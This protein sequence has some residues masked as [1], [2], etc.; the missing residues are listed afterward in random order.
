[1]PFSGSYTGNHAGRY[2][3]LVSESNAT[4]LAAVRV[5]SETTYI[6]DR[7][8]TGFSIVGDDDKGLSKEEALAI[9]Q[10]VV[11]QMIVGG[12][13]INDITRNFE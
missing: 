9:A 12:A 7:E 3:V 8:A 4:K 10:Q 2:K 1:M 11:C 5:V 13:N 6:D